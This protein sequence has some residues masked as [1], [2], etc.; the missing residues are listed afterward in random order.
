M[1]FRAFFATH[2]GNVVSPKT[3]EEFERIVS[4]ADGVA[5]EKTATIIL[6]SLDS[7]VRSLGKQA[8]VPILMVHGDSDQS[9]P[10]EASVDHL[11]K[12]L[13]RPK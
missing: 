12:V 2:A 4:A 13:P 7:E 3:L 11:V 10:K 1:R 9:M 6:R 5:L 8:E